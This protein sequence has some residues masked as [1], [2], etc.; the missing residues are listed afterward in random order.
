[1]SW[2]S[3]SSHSYRLPSQSSNRTLPVKQSRGLGT[4]RGP[5]ASKS[6][7]GSFNDIETNDTKSI[8]STLT[9][10]AN[11]RKPGFFFDSKVHKFDQEY[12]DSTN[13]RKKNILNN[14]NDSIKSILREDD[15]I[16]EASDLYGFNEGDSVNQFK[17]PEYKIQFPNI[18]KHDWFFGHGGSSDSGPAKRFSDRTRRIERLEKLSRNQRR[19]PEQINEDQVSV[20]APSELKSE[21][22]SLNEELQSNNSYKNSGNLQTNKLHQRGVA[23]SAKSSTSSQDSFGSAASS[24]PKWFFA[25]GNRGGLSYAK[26]SLMS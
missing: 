10:V 2:Y 17:I 12:I 26:R 8:I 11:Y 15:N 22:S 14:Q 4:R 23:K 20:K 5:H 21:K 24:V 1:M 19:I 16:N 25:S 6:V 18:D 3:E 9:K 13:A 7:P